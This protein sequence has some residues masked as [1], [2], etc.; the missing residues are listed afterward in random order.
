VRQGAWDYITKP[1]DADQIL[2]ALQRDPSARH[3]EKEIVTPS[4]GRLEWEH[5][6]RVLKDN[7]G[8]VSQTAAVLGLHR[9]SLQRKLRKFPPNG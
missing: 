6:Q 8:N 9:R 3:E 1:A 4:L 7:D 5:I 2:A